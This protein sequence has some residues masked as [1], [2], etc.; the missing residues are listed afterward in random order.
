[1]RRAALL[2][3]FVAALLAPATAV[4][5]RPSLPDIENEVM[6]V[7]CEIPLNIA[8]SAQADQ[9]RNLIR[10][11][12]AQGRSKEQI[13]TALVTEYGEDVLALPDDSGFGITAYAIPLALVALL[14]GGL[15][16]LL[17]RWRRRTPAGIAEQDAPGLSDAE[18]RRLDDELARYER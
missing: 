7:S 8:E 11:L 3:A 13:K 1:M 17:P 9:Q 4:A 14:A 18:S 12:I 15:F 2:L 6:C 16:V 5:Q 10:T